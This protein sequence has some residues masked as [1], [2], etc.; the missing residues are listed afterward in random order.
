MAFEDFFNKREIWA[1]SE[2]PND[3]IRKY[4]RIS[5]RFELTN[6]GMPPELCFV[7]ARN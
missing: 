7:H 1:D 3:H 5:S 2:L 4:L 6:D